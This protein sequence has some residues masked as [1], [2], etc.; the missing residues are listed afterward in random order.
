MPKISGAV[1]AAYTFDTPAVGV[2]PTGTLT[3][4]VQY[5]YRGS[6]WAR[7]FNEPGLDRVGA[8]GVTNFN[9]DYVLAGTGVKLSFTAT[10]AF[11]V[12]GVNSRYTDPYGTGQTSQQYIPPRQ[13][14]GTVA[15][16]F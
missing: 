16:A 8:Y 2:L 5:V 15:Y 12:D 3:P 9:L 14:I 4:R 13:I 6:E 11:N 1:S 7:I 10:N